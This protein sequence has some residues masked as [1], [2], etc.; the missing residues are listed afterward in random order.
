MV[1]EPTIE[2]KAREAQVLD[3]GNTQEDRWNKARL[4]KI[5][6]D[7]LYA[8]ERLLPLV[9]NQALNGDVKAQKLILDRTVPPL[10]AVS[11]ALPPGLP[12]GD[13]V[14]TLQTVMQLIVSGE[15]SPT[16][17]LDVLTMVKQISEFQEGATPQARSRKND[18]AKAKARIARLETDV[19]TCGSTHLKM[20]MK[21]SL[22]NQRKELEAFYSVVE[23]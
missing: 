8:T 11:P 3:N 5:E 15:V 9:V 22:A 12:T 7:L 14:T 18:I 10:K 23:Y 20:L 16:V 19:A 21:K 4:L 2:M 6:S 1:K 17:G 13:I